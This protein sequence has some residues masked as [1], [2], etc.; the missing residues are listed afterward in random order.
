LSAERLRLPN[1][2]L[3]LAFFGTPELARTILET[4]LDAQEDDVALLVCQPDRPRGR[5]R[6]VEPPPTKV[7]A[8]ARGVPVLQPLKMKDGS[9]A[10]ALRERAIDL[11]LVAAYGRILTADTLA[12]T[13]HGFWNVHASLLPRH[14]GASPIQHAILAGDPETGVDLMVMTEGLD[15]GP[16]LRRARAPIGATTTAAE[17]SE[18]LAVL[19]GRIALHGLRAAKREGL[20]VTPQESAAATWAPLLE[21][22]EGRL[23]LTAPAAALDRRVRA[24][25]PWPGTFLG[26]GDRTLRI[27]AG[28]VVPGEG[29]PGTVLE[30]GPRLVLACGDGAYEVLR[31]QP[32]GKGAVAA[33]DYL[34]GAGRGL[35][36]GSPFVF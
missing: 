2:R 1:R 36:A 29:A 32:A 7:L 19:G 22:S 33:A 30:A 35:R 26:E 17:L 16:V 18:T 28:R 11:A 4:L 21:K 10:A 15:E 5:S 25:D 13:V 20:L 24:F 9:L 14:R 34:R 6:R 12:A 31:L 3:R 8:E 23:D 27:L